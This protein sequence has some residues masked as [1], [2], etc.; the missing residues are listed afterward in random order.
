MPQFDISKFSSQIFWFAICFSILYYFV[1]KIILPR[2][3]NIIEE[4]KKAVDSDILS[5]QDVTKDVNDLNAKTKT[6]RQ[7]ATQKYQSRLEEAHKE[8][9]AR[10]EKL[11][12]EMKEKIEKITQKSQDDITKFVESTQSQSQ[13]AIDD[14]VKTIKSKLF[15]VS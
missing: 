13:S 6:L 11:H 2:I 1:S 4:R 7:E 15:N 10:R 14:L 9:S 8:S 3:Q 12:E 5:S